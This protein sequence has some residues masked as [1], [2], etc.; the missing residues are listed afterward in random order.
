MVIKMRNV[1]IFDTFDM[2]QYDKRNYNVRQ[3]HPKEKYNRDHVDCLIE[4]EVSPNIS[5]FN[6]PGRREN[7]RI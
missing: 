3:K 4:P 7:F 6:S 2:S 5:F 1:A